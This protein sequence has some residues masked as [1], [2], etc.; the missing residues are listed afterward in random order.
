MN[1]NLAGCRVREGVGSGTGSHCGGMACVVQAIPPPRGGCDWL[2]VVLEIA[3]SRSL[4]F[5]VSPCLLAPTPPRE[6]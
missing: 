3:A 6:L 2:V 1:Q 5:V 4:S